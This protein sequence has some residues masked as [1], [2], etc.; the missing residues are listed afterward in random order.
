MYL[1]IKTVTILY[2]IIQFLS[3]VFNHVLMELNSMVH[4]K[5]PLKQTNKKKKTHNMNN[6]TYY[7]IWFHAEL[8][9]LT[10]LS[11]DNCNHFDN[12]IISKGIFLA[13]MPNLLL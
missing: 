8:K 5:W 6:I 13:K 9:E 4:T 1:L 12:R 10:I 2:E 7:L 3:G 11:T